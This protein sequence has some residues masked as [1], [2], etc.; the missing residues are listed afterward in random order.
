MGYFANLEVEIMDMAR[1]LGDASGDNADTVLIIARI[2][3]VN[4]AEV[5]R[6]LH[7]DFD[8]DL[9]EYAEASAD[10]DAIHYGEI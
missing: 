6:I 10:L 8:E 9:S 5:Q 1:G 7:A 2:M 4:P 3:G